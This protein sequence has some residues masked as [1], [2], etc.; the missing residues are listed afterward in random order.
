LFS[1]GAPVSREKE[2][3]RRFCTLSYELRRP[4]VIFHLWDAFSGARSGIHRTGFA[5]SH[6]LDFAFAAGAVVYEEN[7]SRNHL[8]LQWLLFEHLSIAGA[9]CSSKQS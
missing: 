2:G 4:P 1:I 3:P 7:R 6:L 5:A 8:A 9:A